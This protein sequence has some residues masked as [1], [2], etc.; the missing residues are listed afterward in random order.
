[1]RQA[2]QLDDG[3]GMPARGEVCVMA[4]LHL[5]GPDLVSADTACTVE[6]CGSGRVSSRQNKG[7][8]GSAPCCTAPAGA[9][10]L[11]HLPTEVRACV[12]ESLLILFACAWNNVRRG[13][14]NILWNCRAPKD[15]YALDCT[16]YIAVVIPVYARTEH[17]LVLLVRV[18]QHLS[19]QQRSANLTVLVSD[20]SPLE[21]PSFLCQGSTFLISLPSNSGPA[22]ARNC[23][24]AKAKQHGASII[25]FCDADCQPA[26][27]WLATMENA[28][29]QTPGI[30]CGMTLS[31]A[32]HTAIGH[33]HEVFGTLNGRMLRDGSVLYGC[34]CNLS[35]SVAD[36]GLLFDISF[37]TAAF[38]DV[39]FCIRAKKQGITL[40][41]NPKAVVRHH[42][43]AGLMALYQQFQRYGRYERL[44]ALRHEEYLP[45]LHASS[46]IS[47]LT[48]SSSA[49]F[50]RF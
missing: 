47:C 43:G 29:Q 44:A 24:I 26:P 10:V 12:S 37:P 20:G 36:V 28:Q 15:G 8:A 42:Y 40:T 50:L 16:N 14:D 6:V 13:A 45:W 33:Y 22:V 35:I 3:S 5:A 41:Y 17:D 46:E 7:P 34:T 38:E 32:P 18:L 19:Q 48:N 49:L 9:A 1:M 30:V 2:K 4:C 11:C 25:C 39:E 23:G 21:I 27:D 31:H